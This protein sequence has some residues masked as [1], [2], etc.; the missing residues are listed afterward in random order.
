[1]RRVRAWI[2]I[3]KSRLVATS[4]LARLALALMCA[5]IIG[6]GVWLA[7]GSGGVE[8][9]A[10]SGKGLAPSDLAEAQSA[11]S[12]KGVSVRV[13]GGRLMARR[14]QAEHARSILAAEGLLT[15]PEA[16]P[17]E[18]LA[19]QD[20]LWCTQAQ[21]NKRWQAAKMAALSSLIR[22]FP[23]IR[24]ATVLFEEG[25]GRGLGG[26]GSESTAS[27]TVELKPDAKMN[28]RL[29]A[30]IADLVCGSIAG[31]K[32]ANVRIIDS[33]GRSYRMNEGGGADSL[34]QVQ[35]AEAYYTDKIRGALGIDNPIITVQVDAQKSPIHCV[36]AFV[37]IPRSYFVSLA[38]S[39]YGSAGEKELSAAMADGLERAREALGRAMKDTAD[40]RVEW[41]W[42]AHAAAAAAVPAAGDSEMTTEFDRRLLASSALAG[43]GVATLVVTIF[44]TRQGRRDELPGGPAGSPLG[45]LEMASPRDIVDFLQGEHPQT[46][47][48]VLSQLAADK[49]AAVLAELP[50]DV[51]IDASRRIASLEKVD[52]AT[53]AEVQETLAGRLSEFAARAQSSIGGQAKLAELLRRAGG[54]TEKNVMDSLSAQEPAVAQSLRSRLFVFDDILTMSDDRLRAALEAMDGEQLA[55]ALRTAGKELTQKVFGCLSAA[56]GRR[57]RLTMDRIGPVRLSD[58]EAAQQRTVDAIVQAGGGLYVPMPHSEMM[59]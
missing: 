11:L 37:S 5:L 35:A 39:Q 47:A 10:V 21:N 43:L 57:L 41:H 3:W 38:Q 20:D 31:L 56:A 6:G 14:D 25:A 28:D 44:R 59:A 58:V 27:V 15:A 9:V 42:D 29:V 30:A 24:T 19:G 8:M 51:Q 36:S 33:A 55:V 26:A 49:A 45:V 53:L 7:V 13:E 23:P 50:K 34:E 18:K 16:G 52:L 1:M 46:V 4:R 2:R 40:L 22:K 17:L 54:A 48:V 32:P 12:A